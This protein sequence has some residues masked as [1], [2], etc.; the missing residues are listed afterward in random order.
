MKKIYLVTLLVA[1]VLISCKKETGADSQV[2]K[3]ITERIVSLNGGITEV[4]YALGFENQIVGVDVTSTYPK[5]IKQK[6]L[7][8]GHVRSV[9][10]EQIIGL[11]PTIVLASDK[12]LNVEVIDK[13]KQANIRVETITQE[14]SVEGTKQ[15]IKDVATIFKSDKYQELITN[16]EVQI[17]KVQPIEPKPKVLFIYARGAGTLMVAGTDTPMEKIIQ[18]GGAE[19]AIKDFSDFKPLTSEALINNNPDVILMFEKGLESLGGIDG[20]LQIQGVEQTNAGKNKKIIAMDGGFLTSFG[21]R[22]GEAAAELN[23]KLRQ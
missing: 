16:I 19:N 20:V 6:A 21:V 23:A 11:K 1:S 2:D 14:Q 3:Q 13:L 9:S 7:D 18:I 8:L 4:L 10:L 5:G 17:Q 15:L 22:V 12:D